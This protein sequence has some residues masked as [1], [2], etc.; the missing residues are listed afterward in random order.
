MDEQKVKDLTRSSSDRY[1]ANILKKINSGEKIIWNQAAFWGTFH[2]MIYRK[3]FAPAFLCFAFLAYLFVYTNSLAFLVGYALIMI[4]SGFFGNALYYMYVKSRLGRGF[5]GC[6]THYMP[7]CHVA[8]F[9]QVGIVYP[10][11]LSLLA[12]L[13]K[14]RGWAHQN[15]ELF[16][17]STQKL[18]EAYAT[19]NPTDYQTLLGAVFGIGFV[20][21]LQFV[22]LPAFFCGRDLFVLWKSEKKFKGKL[23]KKFNDENIRILSSTKADEYYWK[24]FNKIEKGAIFS[25]NFSACFFGGRLGFFWFLYQKAYK[26]AAVSGVI[27]LIYFLVSIFGNFSSQL[28]SALSILLL[29]IDFILLMG[30][31]NHIYYREIKNKIRAE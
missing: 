14:F 23:D 18:F 31:A 12:L 30:G 6:G 27:L 10:S 20:L 11:L 22:I 7:V 29:A 4:L 28:G 21:I 24:Q 17:N 13:G 19:L 2:W 16:D 3:M 8:L 26:A 9:T 5:T 25:L 1:Y 15:A